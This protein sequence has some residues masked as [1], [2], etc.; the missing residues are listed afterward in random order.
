MSHK[1]LSSAAMKL[2][3]RRRA[4]LAEKLL[5]SLDSEAQRKIDA[6]WGAHAERL[7]DAFDAGKIRSKPVAKLIAKL[8]NRTK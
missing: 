4:I 1:E 5:T 6:E 2:S 3:P 7:I 8:R